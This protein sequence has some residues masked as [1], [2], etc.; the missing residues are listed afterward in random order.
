METGKKYN[1]LKNWIIDMLWYYLK[2]DRTSQM[3]ES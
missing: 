2:T 1:N 3:G